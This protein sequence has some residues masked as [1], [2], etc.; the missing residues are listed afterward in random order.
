MQAR[1]KTN[2]NIQNPVFEKGPKL[3]PENGRKG[4]CPWPFGSVSL[5]G[6]K[7]ITCDCNS[8]APADARLGMAR[9]YLLAVV[10]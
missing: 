3:S 4:R 7:L 8:T 9:C 2:K 1:A 5:R 6:H 10:P